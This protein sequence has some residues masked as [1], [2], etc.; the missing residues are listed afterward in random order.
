MKKLMLLS[1]PFICFFLLQASGIRAQGKHSSLTQAVYLSKE[2]DY[3]L[4]LDYCNKAIGN[5]PKNADAYYIR[6]YARYNL[7]NYASAIKDFDTTLK[8][9]KNHADAY[10][11][12]GNCK[13]ELNKYWGALRD[14]RRAKDIAP[15]ITNMHLIKNLVSAL[16]S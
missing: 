7:G 15:E 6:G 9:N 8:L 11:Y 12:R 5:N 10:L 13:K 4:A 16:F 14:Y 2:G 3:E 1:G